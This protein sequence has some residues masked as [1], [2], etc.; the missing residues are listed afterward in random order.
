MYKLKDTNLTGDDLLLGIIKSID[1]RSAKVTFSEDSVTV[2]TRIG[3]Y[4]V[5]ADL[6]SQAI[7]RTKTLSNRYA[8]EVL[9]FHFEDAS[10]KVV[11]L[12]SLVN[13]SITQLSG[14]DIKESLNTSMFD[15]AFEV[16]ETLNKTQCFK[17]TEAGSDKTKIFY[18]DGLPNSLLY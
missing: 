7:T 8:T 13:G 10:V 14:K 9:D 6:D 1:N 18:G 15:F 2:I 16:I 4:S 11:E 3:I 17:Y 12:K 5:K